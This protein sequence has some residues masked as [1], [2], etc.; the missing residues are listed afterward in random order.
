MAFQAITTAKRLVNILFLQLRLF[1]AVTG[2][3]QFASLRDRMSF[4]VRSMWV[5]TDKTL[6][7]LDGSVYRALTVPLCLTL[8][9]G[10]AQIRIQICQQVLVIRGM[11]LMTPDALPFA[12]GGMDVSLLELLHIVLVTLQAQRFAAFCQ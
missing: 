9:A 12:Y 8:V 10:E 1:F 7:Y 4:R 3:A 2:V 5:M 6:T 11:W